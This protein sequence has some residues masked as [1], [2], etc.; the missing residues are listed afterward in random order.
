MSMKT[1]NGLLGAAVLVMATWGGGGRTTSSAQG[2]LW[3][4]QMQGGSVGGAGMPDAAEMNKAMQQMQAQL[5][6]MPPEQRKMIEAQMGNVG[7]A[8]SGNGGIR[9]CLTDEDIKRDAIPV[10]D[11]K[12]TTTVKSRT[13]LALGGGACAA[14]SRPQPVKQKWCSKGSR[15]P[16]ARH[17]RHDSAMANSSPIDMKHEHASCVVRIAVR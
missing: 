13:A 11:G 14:R 1:L 2:G 3:E 10:S 16:G 5:A 17:R 9:I 15:L 8:M 4:M 12:C 7:I 6:K